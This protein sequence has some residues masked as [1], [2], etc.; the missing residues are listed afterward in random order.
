M[1]FTFA[2]LAVSLRLETESADPLLLFSLRSGFEPAFREAAGCGCSGGDDCPCPYHLTFARTLSPD[3]AA[4]RRFQKPSLPFVF[5]IPRLPSPPN[6]GA[7]V[8]LG[9]T[10]LGDATRYVSVYLAALR[11][12]LRDHGVRGARVESVGDGGIRQCLQEE[13]G[14][15]SPEGLGLLS[16]RGLEQG[17]AAMPRALALTFV[18][19]LRLV[20]EGRPLRQ[21][22]FSALARALMRRVSSLAYYYGGTELDY[23]YKWLAQES[24]LIESDAAGLQWVAWRGGGGGQ[25]SGLVGRAVFRGDLADFQTFLLLGEYVHLGKGAPYGLG[26][27]RIARIA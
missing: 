3:P 20:H 10:L 9:L 5:D 11:L 2:R 17:V 24:E 19:P 18:T 26:A 21:L 22:S 14:P 4:V 25:A 23:D 13:D 16:L 15:F 8:E 1:E 27:F 6:R 7:E 12:F